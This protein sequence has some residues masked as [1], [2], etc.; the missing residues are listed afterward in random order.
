MR[1][2]RGAYMKRKQFNVS[3]DSIIPGQHYLS[4]EKY[5]RI[6][7]YFEK[8][9]SYGT[10]YV[11][12]YKDKLFSIDGNHRLYYLYNHGVK[13][14][15][16]TNEVSDN[17]SKLYQS[18]ADESVAL[19]LTH[20]NDLKARI[21][22]DDLYQIKWIDKCQVMLL[23]DDI[24]S[25]YKA[26]PCRY[27]SIPLYKEIR[28]NPHQKIT[29]IHHTQYRNEKGQYHGRFLRLKHDLNH[30]P[31]VTLDGFKPIAF[32]KTHDIDK[33]VELINTSYES[34]TVKR[35]TIELMMVDRVYNSKLWYYIVEKQSNKPVA[36]GIAHYDSIVNEISL[37]WI[38]V[39]PKYRN[40][41]IGKLLLRK[42][43]LEASS[44][45]AFATV[46]FDLDNLTSPEHLY[47]R[48][49]FKGHDLW[50]IIKT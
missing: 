43:L 38:Q 19:G 40:K 35:E 50:H 10:I 22:G 34:S 44:I 49:G 46:S 24:I 8:T 17:K 16:V 4:K 6:S 33:A 39:L 36:L 48:M 41:G 18:L 9:S 3:I 21:I 20:I 5:N 1:V 26:N 47:R 14:L 29:V 37:D 25:R 30:I 12:Q 2:Q 7:T 13:T 31:Y 27:S 45:G 15:T 42:L 23:D 32:D 11:I 28:R